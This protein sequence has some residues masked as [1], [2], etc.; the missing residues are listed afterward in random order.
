M[1]E[2]A[3]LP[4]AEPEADFAARLD[5]E[6]ARLVLLIDAAYRHR[7]GKTSTADQRRTIEAAQ[8]RVTQARAG[9]L[10]T[11]IL[12]GLAPDDLALDALACALLPVLRPA[13]A[14][15]IA[16]L[17]GGA[18]LAPTQALLH[19][20]LL[21]S[22]AEDLQMLRLISPAGPLLAG[23]WLSVEGMGPARL[24]RPG[25]R[26][27]RRILG[28]D[29]FGALPAGMVLDDD[30]TGALPDLILPADIARHLDEIA[31]L[32]RFALTAQDGDALSAPAG[33]AVLLTGP[34]GTG[35][36]L[37]ARHLA[38]RL[39]RP[40]F[41]LELGR[42]VSKWLGDTE[43]NLT[44]VF[45]QMSGTRGC[46]LIDECD[47]ILGRRVAVREARDHSANM[48]VSHLLMLLERHRGPVFATSNL[49]NNLDDAY[50]RRFAA[51]VEF[52]RLDPRLRAAAWH[53]AL[54]PEDR[55]DLADLAA[56]IDLPPAEIAN[57]ALY[58]RAL[59]DGAALGPEHL[60][61]AI[62]RERGK[63]AATF[64]GAELMALAPYLPAE[65]AT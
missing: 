32:A 42:I 35:K 12:Q 3:I 64:T 1:T 34:P 37:A 47:A 62:R 52:R 33:P 24:L 22:G 58:A 48:T 65:D 57:A 26:L 40:L 15:R 5:P 14:L 46:I 17:Q 8:G 16:G 6:A 55:P 31:A 29:G 53:A 59:A 25:P 39:K 60:A 20:I 63:A 19:Q 28:E 41:R 61:R 36:S 56:S 51:V 23:G 10:W 45:T 54:G 38:R 2:A 30:G 7:D 50:L 44:E 13:Q 4:F 27:L 21:L 11:R 49:R 18:E 9:G 43:R